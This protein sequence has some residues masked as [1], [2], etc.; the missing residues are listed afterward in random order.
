MRGPAGHRR[1]SAEHAECPGVAVTGV[2]PC[3]RQLLFGFREKQ[4]PRHN[5]EPIF[6]LVDVG[7]DNATLTFEQRGNRPV[8]SLAPGVRP[9]LL[10]RVI[11][12][13]GRGKVGLRVEVDH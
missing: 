11:V 10:N 1:E 12:E 6:D 5:A 3:R 2:R 8:N 7:A 13:E 9:Q 4:I